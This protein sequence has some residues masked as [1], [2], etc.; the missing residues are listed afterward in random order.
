MEVLQDHINLRRAMNAF[1]MELFSKYPFVKVLQEPNEDYYSNFWLSA[2]VI[3]HD[4]KNREGLRLHLESEN[5]ESRPI[6][7]PMH[8][9]PIFENAPFYGGKVAEHLFENGLCLPSGSNLTES[10]RARIKKAV[11]EYFET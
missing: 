1:Y 7:K 4:V 3:N 9:Q 5:I 2:I 8:L 6:W 11:V 10:D